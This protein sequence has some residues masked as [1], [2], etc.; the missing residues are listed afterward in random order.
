MQIADLE[1][2]RKIGEEYGWDEPTIENALS[3]AIRL[4]YAERGMLVEADV[5]MAMGTITCRRR[6]GVGDRGV[7][8][9]IR[10]PIMPSIKM[11]M[12]VLEMQQWGDGSPGRVMEGTVVGYRDGGVIYRVSHNMVYVPENL[13]SVSDY[14]SRP[15]LGDKQVLAMCATRDNSSGMRQATRRGK[16][17]VASVMECH[18]PECISSIWMGASNSWA[19]IRMKADVMSEWLENGGVNVRHLQQVLG[20]R[21]ITL[22]PEGNG[23]T[24]QESRDSEIRHFVNNAW[25]AC[26]IAELSPNR[27]VIHTPMDS[28][29]PRKLRTFTSMLQKIAPEREQVIL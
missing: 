7:W 6:S 9:D 2:V 18:Y 3:N 1:Y 25:K 10:S 4:C 21:R 23:E 16:E 29:D 24:E 11:F 22:I 12:S 8:V 20:I 27:I 26:K 19:V 5:N 17:F 13:L 28:N 14:H 15:K